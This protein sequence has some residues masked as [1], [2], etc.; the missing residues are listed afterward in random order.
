MIYLL[1]GDGKTLRRVSQAGI[2]SG[3]PA[4]PDL[5]SLDGHAESVWPLR[6]VIESGEVMLVE[7]SVTILRKSL[8]ENGAMLRNARSWYRSRSKG[9]HVPLAY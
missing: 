7:I 8:P 3:H 1:E 6:H 2:A 4:A 5:V 9:K